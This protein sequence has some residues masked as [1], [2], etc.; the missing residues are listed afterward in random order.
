MVVD[1]E[2]I[3]ITGAAGAVPGVVFDLIVNAIQQW[4][5]R[6]AGVINVPTF[7]VFTRLVLSLCVNFV[8]CGGFAYVYYIIWK[9]QGDAFLFGGIVWLIVALPLVFS[10]RY[11]DE[12]QRKVLAT[13]VLGWL[14]KIAAAAASATYFIG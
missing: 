13:R 2:T 14:F 6:Q 7:G 8:A 10:S 9:G 4:Q 3:L 5:R 12:I 1:K 11:F